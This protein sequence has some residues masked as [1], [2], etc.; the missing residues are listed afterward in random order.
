MVTSVA[1]GVRAVAALDERAGGSRPRDPDAPFD[2]DGSRVDAWSGDL[3]AK[4]L[5]VMV[6][7]LLAAGAMAVLIPLLDGVRAAFRAL[8]EVSDPRR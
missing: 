7:L 3:D 8:A 4:L 5:T 1:R 6:A 2:R